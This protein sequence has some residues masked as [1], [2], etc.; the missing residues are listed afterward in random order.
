MRLLNPLLFR[1][2]L[3]ALLGVISSDPCSAQETLENLPLRVVISGTPRKQSLLEYG[4]PASVMNE[5]E[6]E[7]RTASTLGE[8]IR[9]EPGVRSSFAGNGASRP[10]VRGFGGDR[11]RVLKNGVLTGDVS[12]MSEDH[13]V[14]ADPM[15][16]KQIEILRGPETLLYGSGAIGGAVNVA[17]DSI[18][19]ESLGK[20]FKGSVLSQFGDSA[21][22]EKTAGVK[23]RAETGGLNWYFSGFARTT[24]DY[25]IPGSAE[26]S[27]LLEAEGEEPA[28]S[29]KLFGSDTETWGSTVGASHVFD[30]GFVGV[31][32][33]GFGSDYGVPGHAHTHEEHDEHGHEDEEHHDEEHEDH[34]I[35]YEEEDEVSEGVR[36]EAG[37]L[38]VDVRGQVDSIS[39][40]IDGI[41]FRMGL[42]DYQHD[43]IEDGNVATEYER[44]M[45]DSRVDLFH[46]EIAGL[47]GSAGFG[48]LYDDFSALGEEAF[49]TPTET[50]TPAFFLFEKKSLTPQLDLDFGG[51]VEFVRHDPRGLESQEFVPFSL[52]TGPRWDITG[53]GSY[54]LAAT[55]AYAE[56][57]PNAVELFADGQHLARQIFE[58]GATSLSKERSWGADIVF[59]KNTGSL[60]AAFTPF[61]QRFS[62]YI[63][64]AGTG[65]EMLD[66]PVY[67]YEETEAYF[68]G[69]EFESALVVSD[70][71]GLSENTVQVEYQADYVRAQED[72][73]S[74]SLPRI[75]PLRNIARL[76]YKY[77]DRLETMVEGVFVEA[78]SRVAEFELPTSSY[79]LLNTEVR[80]NLEAEASRGLQVF[81]R[82]SNLTNEEA[83]I[84][85]SFLKD[86]A[87]LRGR[88]FLV[89]LRGSFN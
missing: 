44:K 6:V 79:S 57:A 51:R 16:A 53:D 64:L 81:L 46:T 41:K 15:Q 48:F 39:D 84:H 3:T 61:Y 43:E 62:N 65:E 77:K 2:S 31:S 69:F 17:D 78:Q 54:T 21:D 27:R 68:W 59:R 5:R 12:D 38:R 24:Q 80:L 45:F 67:Q 70:I 26:S 13:V 85:T 40:T 32:V 8:T 7:S 83:R 73:E 47:N 56:R 74:S 35:G 89:G 22:N 4:K 86:L 52:S 75:P 88:A 30:N 34:V 10:I 23:F 72:Q 76:T 42:T 55:V 18:P 36:I 9:L 25:E 87:P 11:V 50:V 60:T 14:V 49:L 19:E 28:D 82:G 58:Q 33:S 66:L 63:N 20:P 1:C 37:Q 29:G 71:I